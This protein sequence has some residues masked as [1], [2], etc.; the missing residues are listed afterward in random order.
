M[1]KPTC[2]ICRFWFREGD[3]GVHGICRRSPP[4]VPLEDSM[5]VRTVFPRTG[6]AAW[7]GEWRSVGENCRIE[8]GDRVDAEGKGFD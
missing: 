5:G 1:T 2:Q 6:R 3:T 7:C 8:Y 4:S